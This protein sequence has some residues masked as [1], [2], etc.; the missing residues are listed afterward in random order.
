MKIKR[1]IVVLGILFLL[2]AGRSTFA[3]S[4]PGFDRLDDFGDGS[5]QTL[6]AEETGFY[7]GV[8]LVLFGHGTA[9]DVTVHVR[10]LESDGSLA[11]VM[12]ATGFVPASV[13]ST[14]TP[15]WHF[16]QFGSPV[17]IS[18]GESYGLVLNQFGSG[19]SGYVDYGS[20]TGNPYANGRMMH[21]SVSGQPLN[22]IF[23]D[24]DLA[25][26]NV[27]VVP[28]PSG[29]VLGLLGSVAFLVIR[30]SSTHLFLKGSRRSARTSARV[31]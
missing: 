31:M 24:L 6:I 17:S 7:T 4:Q 21:E 2:S 23:P 10:A 30:R 11:P 26:Q 27:V 9:N 14:S 12:L 28:E 16:I 25:F 29:F 19:P 20:S 15:E 18:A 13:I 5:V 22:P 1:R 3:Q 8:S